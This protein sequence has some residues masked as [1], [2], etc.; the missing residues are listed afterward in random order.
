MVVKCWRK[1]KCL[2]HI[3]LTKF[4]FT[5]CSSLEDDK[6]TNH[7]NTS[8]PHRDYVPIKS[9]PFIKSHLT[10]LIEKMEANGRRA[11]QFFLVR[12]LTIIL[13]RK[14]NLFWISKRLNGRILITKEKKAP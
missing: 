9:D 7:C 5:T 10:V 14:K 12:A 4:L 1:K 2:M 6:S 11:G 3:C 13:V 8:P